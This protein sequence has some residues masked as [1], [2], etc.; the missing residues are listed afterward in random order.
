MPFAFGH[1]RLSLG[2]MFQSQ[3]FRRKISLGDKQLD[4]FP[5]IETSA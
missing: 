5:K 1:A 2:G 4:L 3:P